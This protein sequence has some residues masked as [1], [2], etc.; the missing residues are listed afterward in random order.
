[1]PLRRRY[2][3]GAEPTS[4]GVAFR[5]WALDRSRV[6][7]VV[8]GRGDTPLT[9]EEREDA[10]ERG[11]FSGFVAAMRPGERYRFR[12]DGGDAFPDPASRCQPEGPHGP[13][14]VV[15]PNAFRWSDRDAAWRGVPPERR[16]LYELHVG[17]FTA[18]GTFQAAIAEL[19]RLAELGVTLLE[20]MP[21]ADF[22][23]S[24][25]WGYDG[26]DPWA[27]SRNYGTP[28][29]L[30]RFVDA[31][32]THGLGVVLDVV[33][34][35]LGP[36]GNYLGCYA[37]AYLSAKHETEWGQ[38]INFD[39]EDAKPVRE[40]FVE[41]AAYW[42][43]EF[44]LDGLRFD[45]TQV[46]FDDC[47]NGREHVLTAMARRAREAAGERTLFLV[48]ENESQEAYL[49]RSPERGGCG[50]DA[51][52]NDDFHHA[53]VAALTGQREAYYADT[54]GTPQELLSAVRWGYLFQGQRYAWQKKR[55]GHA[56]LDLGGRAFVQYLEN[57]DQVANSRTGARLVELTSPGRLRAMT[58]LLL[59]APSPP[60]L[61]QGQEYGSTRPFL[62]FADHGGELG[63]SVRR[64][65]ATFLRQF[66]SLDREDL[67][68]E[69]DDPTARV[70]FER[71][72][73]DAS[74]RERRPTFLALHRDLL[75]LR[76]RDPAFAAQATDRVAGAVLA[77]D[78][79]VIRF[80]DD[81]G[82]RLLLVNLG[83]QT[84]LA[85]VAEPLLAC[86]RREA[87]QIL[88]STDDPKYG[89]NGVAPIEGDWG[90]TVP[91][92]AAV[93]LG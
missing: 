56:A 8:P 23:G 67:V 17:T 10:T 68:R 83:T 88:W 82:D 92:Q 51:L 61:F 44:H 28:D 33:Y 38:A 3:I 49:A 26:V 6:D 24:F 1:M 47:P 16:V 34:N 77:P 14:E 36:D 48:A 85:N 4:D 52:W 75:A 66:P 9:R 20:L 37:K 53:A 84:T 31:A 2:P 73:L 64:G 58:A 69:L 91:A 7:V 12:L 15:D 80:F 40:L 89:G 74:E 65:R 39:G 18:A 25:G 55:R 62:Y 71:S 86:P 79:F 59:L 19:P 11:Y 41:N 90:W 76:R 63:D 78:A 43:D 50:L 13:S 30:R 93:V 72:K 54:A 29:D 87:W 22:P 46:I 35:H 32:H 45:A 21:I 5:V 57:H 42:I 81:A 27:P 60:M 70:T